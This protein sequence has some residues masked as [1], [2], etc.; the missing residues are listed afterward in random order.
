[1]VADWV[2][3]NFV[4]VGKGGGVS[5]LRKH[6]ALNAGNMIKIETVA[7]EGTNGLTHR[8]KSPNRYLLVIRSIPLVCLAPA[9][10]TVDRRCC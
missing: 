4:S 10:P 7:T 9:H 2:V 1:M 8:Q 6:I 5:L 3:M